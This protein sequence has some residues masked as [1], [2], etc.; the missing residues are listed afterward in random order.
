MINYIS[1]LK[2]ND[3]K[4]TIQRTSILQS[5]DKSGH[6]NVDDIYEDVKRQYPTLSLATI[7]KNI[8]VMQEHN[9]IIE[10]P[11]NGEKSKYELKK[12]EHMHLICQNCGQIKDTEITSETKEAL[13][14]ENFQLKS[15]QINLFGLCQECQHKA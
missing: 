2:E 7:Y 15:S 13:I 12:E 4:A 8:I 10:V 9:V 5:I 6:I 11:M 14:I 3:L 1:L